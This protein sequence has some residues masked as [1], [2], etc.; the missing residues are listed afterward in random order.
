M[1]KNKLLLLIN[2]DYIGETRNP[3]VTVDTNIIFRINE[4]SNRRNGGITLFSPNIFL[5][6]SVIGDVDDSHINSV[7]G[8]RFDDPEYYTQGI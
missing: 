4:S 3:S 6:D 7:L 2:D 1:R 5:H 8:N